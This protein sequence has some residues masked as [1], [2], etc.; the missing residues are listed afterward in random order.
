MHNHPTRPLF[1]HAL[2]ALLVFTTLAPSVADA[3]RRSK[4]DV[5]RWIHREGKKTLPDLLTRERKDA[6]RA[7]KTLIVMFTADWCSPCKAIKE[8]LHESSTVQKAM[9][10]GRMIYIDVDEWRGPAHRLFPGVNPR[11]LPTI[12]ALDAKGAVTVT[13]GGSD[14]GLLSEDSVAD[15]LKRLLAGKEPAPPYYANDPKE[16]QRLIRIQ[17]EAQLARQKGTPQLQVKARGDGTVRL[18]LRNHDGPRRW[19]VIPWKQGDALTEK[20]TVSAWQTVKFDEHVRSTYLRFLGHPSFVAVVV[21]GYGSVTLDRWP[22]DGAKKGKT[23]EVLELRSLQVDGE[24]PE[25]PRKI[26][27]SMTIEHAARGTTLMSEQTATVSMKI[28]A[29]HKATV[30]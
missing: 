11:F 23:L 9:R 24:A 15:N 3:A 17:H 13:C 1:R 27:Y 8:F 22:L 19:F 25:I 10:R 7:G 5:E 6:A 20:M 18:T 30:K 29:R 21:G 2:V 14:L 26:P 12:A 4:K 28:K 16:K